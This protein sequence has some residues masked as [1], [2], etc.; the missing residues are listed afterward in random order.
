MTGSEIKSLLS[1]WAATLE[2]RL[3]TAIAPVREISAEFHAAIAHALLGGGKRLRPAL[4][5]ESARMLG[6]SF[7]TALPGALAVEMIHSYSLVHDDLPCMD[8]DDLRRGRPTVHAA[9]GE[10]T[11]VLV[12][13]ALLTL[14]FESLVAG[15]APV[16][17]R[18]EAVAVLA[19][20][21]G[22]HGMVGGQVLDLA[23]EGAAPELARVEAIHTRKT[24]A[25]LA[26][27]CEIGSIL[28]AASPPERE[29]IARYGQRIGLAF[30]I[31]DDCLDETSTSEQLGKTAHKDRDSGK[32]T[33]PACVGLDESFTTAGRLAKEAV[34]AL[35]GF[36]DE[37]ST[38][39][40]AL[41]E[42][43]VER[44]N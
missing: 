43:V 3:A 2:P 19:R 44:R 41:A 22:A 25:L 11:A 4:A 6:A 20:A 12:G 36:P 13:D 15:P 16:D 23:G 24:A 26:A 1:H 21:S 37:D 10:A 31:V 29:A 28:A 9:Y 42:F 32:L 5:I 33:W 39:L 34:A 8:D 38:F 14:A 18:V 17:R 30:Q 35:D 7:D 40:R 27:S